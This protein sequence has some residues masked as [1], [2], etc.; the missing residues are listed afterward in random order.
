MKRNERAMAGLHGH[1][2]EQ[3]LALVPR[4]NATLLDVGC[5]TGALL[6]RLE[7]QGYSTLIGIDISPPSDLAGV[8]LL[9]CDL[10]AARTS[11]PDQS[12]DFAV[13]VEVFEHVENM[14]AL[15]AE[16]ARV[17]APQGMLLLT[18]PNVHSLEAR[19]RF[20]LLGKLKQ[21]DEIGDPTHIYPIFQLPF[22]RVLSRYGLEVVNAWGFPLDGSSPSSRPGLRWLA[23]AA[24]AFGLKDGPRGDQLCMLIRPIAVQT[25]AAADAKRAQV[26][27]HY[28]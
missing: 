14:G 7:D 13:S 23:R 15:L 19:I 22:G 10:D 2:L 26:T 8:T 4:K 11:I 16:I 27:S 25:I 6:V 1:S 3:V 9:A 28:A 21:F 17:L 24:R 12:V 5:G 18:T 20:L